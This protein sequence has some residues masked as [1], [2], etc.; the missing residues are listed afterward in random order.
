M[1]ARRI[2]SFSCWFGCGVNAWG[3]RPYMGEGLGTTKNKTSLPYACV[4]QAVVHLGIRAGAVE[5]RNV[6]SHL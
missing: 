6:T 5:K 4:A 3:L 2:V 1:L